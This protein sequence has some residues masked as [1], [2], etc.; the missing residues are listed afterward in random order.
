MCS[1]IKST[2]WGKPEAQLA[3][4]MTQNTSG[5]RSQWQRYRA[6]LGK[7]APKDL[8]AFQR[9]KYTDAAGWEELKSTY[10]DVRWMRNAQVN[11]VTKVEAHRMPSFAEPDTVTDNYSAGY[12]IQRRYY[13]KTG[14]PRLDIDLSN[15]GNAKIHSIVPHYH[16][17]Q[18]FNEGI[19]R[20]GTSDHA[21]TEAMKIANQDILK[22]R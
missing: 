7:D 1:G 10:H 6:V 4:R 13:G 11:S 16:G 18:E 9:M 17:W 2:S 8:A 14:R 15:H 21:L 5:D 19:V 12:I 20:D 22:R 3:E